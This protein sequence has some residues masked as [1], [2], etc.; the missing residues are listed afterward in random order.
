[1]DYEKKINKYF[2]RKNEL[3]IISKNYGVEIFIEKIGSYLK[4]FEYKKEKSYIYSF[5]NDFI[6]NKI[7]NLR[8]KDILNNKFLAET[9]SEYKE[10]KLEEFHKNYSLEK[11]IDL[12]NI[13]EDYQWLITKIKVDTF[14]K[15]N[16]KEMYFEILKNV[17]WYK[18]LIYRDIIKKIINHNKKVKVVFEE[19]INNNVLSNYKLL[20]EIMDKNFDSMKNVI[21][22]LEDKK[23][24][25]VI[26]E[27]AKGKS[28]IFIHVRDL[29]MSFNLFK[30]YRCINLR[31]YQKKKICRMYLYKFINYKR[32]EVFNE[33]L[34]S[35]IDLKTLYLR[36]LSVLCEINLKYQQ[37]NKE[38]EDMEENKKEYFLSLAE[39][40]LN[41][42]SFVKIDES[43]KEFEEF[44]LIKKNINNF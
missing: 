19:N 3:H 25:K 7:K 9:Y 38:N 42:I 21:E 1:M 13:F 22:Y 27:I 20:E 26:E 16:Y 8:L 41:K 39:E 40:L 34:S 44:I 6:W 30:K 5:D 36:E 37:E 33:I 18:V 14:S 35:E 32:D 29:K 24:F 11:F 2:E 31:K 23:E 43:L 10:I 15:E 12:K 28:D 17:D 4:I